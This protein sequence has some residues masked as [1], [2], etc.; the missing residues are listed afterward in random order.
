MPQLSSGT[1]RQPALAEK[2]PAPPPV[3]QNVDLA[4][5]KGTPLQVALDDEVRVRKVGQ[6]VHGK[7]VEPVYAFDHV[8]VPVGSEVN[9]EISK[10]ETLSNE[11]RTLAALDGR[12]HAVAEGGTH[13]QGTGLGGWQAHSSAHHRGS[14]IRTSHKA[15]QRV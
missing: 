12:F 6:P 11:K 2:A 10:I 13:L 15:G 4:V 5:P 7:T 8:V 3:P 9:G 1:A 14:G